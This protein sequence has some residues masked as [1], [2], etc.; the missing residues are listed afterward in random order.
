MLLNQILKLTLTYL[1][2]SRHLKED[3]F[4]G[5]ETDICVQ[6]K[7]ISWPEGDCGVRL[8]EKKQFIS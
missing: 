4:D 3:Y 5:N 2:A 6:E 7:Q 8:K 1:T